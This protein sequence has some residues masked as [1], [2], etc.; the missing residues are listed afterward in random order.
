VSG[1]PRQI[2]R[3]IPGLELVE[4]QHPDQCCGSA[5]V[6]NIM[7]PEPAGRILDAKM[8]DIMATQ[9]DLV[10]TSNTGCHLQLIAG[11]RRSRMRAQVCHV[12]EVLELSYKA[13]D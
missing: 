4:L 2:L 5:G 12:V 3:K 8:A 1:A 9:A 6:Y 10:I 13:A 7:H 11:V